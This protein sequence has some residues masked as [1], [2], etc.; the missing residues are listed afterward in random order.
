MS[1]SD[2]G[3]DFL[4]AD[5]GRAYFRISDFLVKIP[6]NA[7]GIEMNKDEYHQFK[8]GQLADVFNPCQNLD[9]NNWLYMPYIEDC[10]E[11]W[12]NASDSSYVNCVKYDHSSDL[13]LQ[14]DCDGQC[15]LC[16]YNKHIVAQE[17]FTALRAV[18]NA[19][20]W[21]VGINANGECRFYAYTNIQAKSSEIFLD[22]GYLD[23]FEEYLEDCE[24]DILF[25]KWVIGREVPPAKIEGPDESF[26]RRVNKVRRKMF[27]RNKRWSGLSNIW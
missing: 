21:R 23:L 20:L 11:E 15:S 22:G 17:V 3:M 10:T 24:Y 7:S 2:L 5:G 12:L 1:N 4:F 19:S 8:E 18:P 9:E 14:F 27:F 16:L 13:N 26:I 25:S 6:Y